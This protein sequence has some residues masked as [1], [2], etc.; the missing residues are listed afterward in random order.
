MNIA[1]FAVLEFLVRLRPYREEPNSQYDSLMFS[2]SQMQLYTEPMTTL[3]PT[4]VKHI[5]R[6]DVIPLLDNPE[7]S[8]TEAICI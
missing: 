7:L 2:F 6:G 4:L 1:S 5:G 8:D 3:C